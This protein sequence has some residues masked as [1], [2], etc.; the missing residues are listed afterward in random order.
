[1]EVGVV[2]SEACRAGEDAEGDA[3][4]SDGHDLGRAPQEW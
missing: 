4:R 1:M 3:L 2:V